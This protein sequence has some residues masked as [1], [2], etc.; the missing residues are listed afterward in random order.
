MGKK[1]EMIGNKYGRL[2]VI[3]EAPSQHGHAMWICKCDCGNTT[4]PIGGSDL[5]NGKVQSCKCLHNEL[6]SKKMTKHKMKETRLYRIWTNMRARCRFPSVPCYGSY[7]GRGV[8]VC[9]EW[10]HDFLAFHSWAMANGYA[11]DLTLDRKD[12]NGPYRPD[13]CRWVSRKAQANNL[14]K[15]VVLDINGEKHTMAEW[16]DISGIKYTTI[17]QRR[18]RGWADDDLL[19]PV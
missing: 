13:N 15:N 2:T 12:T 16:A 11:D 18:L 8:T 17:Y 1:I 9:E 19:K 14:R 5:R 10:Q 3:E 6:V 4:H 7:G